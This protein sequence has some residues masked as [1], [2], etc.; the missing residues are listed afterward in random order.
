M[1]NDGVAESY[2]IPVSEGRTPGIR[3]LFRMFSVD[4]E[5]LFPGV[6]AVPVVPVVVVVDGVGWPPD[7]DEDGIGEIIWEGMSNMG[8]RGFELLLLSRVVLP[9]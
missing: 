5:L 8:Q 6:P 3:I 2:V 7:G 4:I 9:M 1:K